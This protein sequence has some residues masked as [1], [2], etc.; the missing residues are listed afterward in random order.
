MITVIRYVDENWCE[1]ELNSSFGIFPISFVEVGI[2][3]IMLTN[4]ERSEGERERG[5]EGGRD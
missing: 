2:V 3:F 1:G 5:R 4:Q